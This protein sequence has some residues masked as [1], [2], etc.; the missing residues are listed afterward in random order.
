M[1]TFFL[2][3]HA[4]H[5]NVGGY[6]AGRTPGVVLGTSGLAQAERLG[7]RMRRERFSAIYAS[8]RERTQQTAQA[9]A[10]ACG[11]AEVR[12]EAA[13]DEIDFGTWSGRDFPDLNADWEWRR[14]NSVRSIA[15]TPS[16]ETVLDVQH[17]VIG[18]MAR[19]AAEDSD[20][21]LA[22][23]T[24]ADVIKIAVA[25]YLGLGLDSWN[26]FDVEPASITTIHV[27]P[28]NARLLGLNER[29]DWNA[30][31]ESAP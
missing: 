20:G 14:W 28:W 16:G 30:N 23:V 29:V 17:R 10:R 4:A 19:L 22:L 21:S 11:I 18:L 1:T 13:L 25:Y 12:T 8:P 26:R 3:R 5:D 7:R 9:V 6:L 31:E 27:E 24:H 2:L 15:K